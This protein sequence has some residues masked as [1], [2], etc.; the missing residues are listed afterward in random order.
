MKRA[1]L[2]IVGSV[3]LLV[4]LVSAFAGGV[5]AAQ[6]VNI[7]GLLGIV[8]TDSSL[9]EQ[10]RRGRAL[11]RSAGTRTLKRGLEE[12]PGRFPVS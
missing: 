11:A 7:P 12:R 6:L 5:A 4:L 2:Y 10:G 9:S 8:Q 3:L 1:T